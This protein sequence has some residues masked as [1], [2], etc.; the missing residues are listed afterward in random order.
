MI[1]QEDILSADEV[2]KLLQVHPRTIKRL[3]NQRILIGFQVAGKWRFRRG[4]VEE[5]IRK[6]ENEGQKNDGRTH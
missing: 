2:A 6:Q 1:V 5:Y 3:A 4:A